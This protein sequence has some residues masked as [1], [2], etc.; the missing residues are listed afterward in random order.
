MKSKLTIEF[1]EILMKKSS[2]SDY[3]QT[4]TSMN[5]PVATYSDPQHRSSLPVTIN[6]NPHEH[7]Q[8][9]NAPGSGPIPLG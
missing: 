4:Q 1:F 9:G 7:S 6:L 8:G 3:D 5:N 2:C